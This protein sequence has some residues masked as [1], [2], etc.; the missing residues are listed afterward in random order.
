MLGLQI[1]TW[2]WYK[3][4]AHTAQRIRMG[5]TNCKVWRNKLGTDRIRVHPTK[6][7]QNS[8]CRCLHLSASHFMNCNPLWNSPSFHEKIT[9]A[10]LNSDDAIYL[11][12]FLLM[13]ETEAELWKNAVWL[14]LIYEKFRDFLLLFLSHKH[15]CWHCTF[16]HDMQSMWYAFLLHI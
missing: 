5:C 16:L 1:L 9:N 4:A 14:F 2:L 3:S 15:I 10:K 8:A 12:I 7:A 6:S 13:Q 11:S